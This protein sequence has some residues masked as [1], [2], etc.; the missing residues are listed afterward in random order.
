MTKPRALPTPIRVG[1]HLWSVRY[2]NAACAAGSVTGATLHD[3]L[4][5]IMQSEESGNAREVVQETLLHE[6]FHAAWGQTPLDADYP[7]EAEERIIGA[8]SPIIWSALKDSP[9]LRKFL[10]L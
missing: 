5:I 7:D 9:A 1:A 2:D 3:Q 10:G 6:V 4:E 8:L